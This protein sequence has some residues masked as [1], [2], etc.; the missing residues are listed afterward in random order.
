MIILTKIDIVPKAAVEA[1]VRALQRLQP[2]ATI[3]LSAHAG[4]LLPQL[5]ATPAPKLSILKSRAKQFKLTKK[6][7]TA[8]NVDALVIRDSRPFHPERLHEACRSKLGTG[9]Y[10]TKGFLWLASRSGHVLMWQ[11]SGS[12]IS[13]ELSG[14]WRAEIAHNQDG[15]LTPDEVD[16][17]NAQLKTK[18]PVFGDRHNE[19]TL[20]GLKADRESFA[21]ALK[22]ALC[23]DEEVIAWQKGEVFT[24]PWPKSL[25][26]A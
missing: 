21:A 9:L 24:D 12:Q 25:R 8:N 1:Q 16:Q 6:S 15:S 23:T 7:S 19:L 2:N 22:E 10:R 18:H 14:Y 13:L 4:V 20:I 5:D 17:L 11:Q 26:R 3:A